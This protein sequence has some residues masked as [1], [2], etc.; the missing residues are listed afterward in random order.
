MDQRELDM[1]GKPCPQPVIET[2]RALN[3]MTEGTLQVLLDNEVSSKNVAQFAAGAGHEVAREDLGSGEYVV[4]IA[5][6]A[7]QEAAAEEPAVVC[8][9][10]SPATTAVAVF[11]NIMGRGDEELGAI[12]V[13][14]FLY[15][16]AEQPEPPGTIIFANRGVELCCE[17][18]PAIDSVQALADKGAT[19][20]ACGTC[21][22]FL[23]LKEKLAVGKISN[24]YEIVEALTE[25][26]KVI[27]P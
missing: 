25:A 24:M 9:I 23:G 12:L 14:S 7:K 13:T 1:R 8:G 16:L 17:G 26:S 15:T 3:E 27:A 18:S 2:R 11:S 19:V 10:P 5:A 21:L 20:L 4:R 6:Q 22:D